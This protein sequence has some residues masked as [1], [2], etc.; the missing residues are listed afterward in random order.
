MVTWKRGLAGLYTGQDVGLLGGSY[1]ELTREIRGVRLNQMP[2]ASRR[3]LWA[4]Q[5]SFKV[6]RTE[7]QSQGEGK[8]PTNLRPGQLPTPPAAQQF[9]VA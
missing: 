4:S 8:C 1:L 7:G 6:G 3:F 5:D 2:R 9:G